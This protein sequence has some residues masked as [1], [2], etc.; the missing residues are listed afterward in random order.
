MG[1]IIEARGLV[2]TFE[3]GVTRIHALRG[4]DLDLEEG[5]YLAIVGPSGSGKSTL[6]NLL[7]CLDT[8][9][10]GTYRLAGEEVSQLNEL[11]LAAIRNR[12]IG[13]VF[14]TFNLLPATLRRPRSARRRARWG[15]GRTSP[16]NAQRAGVRRR[17]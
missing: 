14:Q 9:S 15:S 13:F 4:T 6:M 7:G 3:M 2:R 5:D 16:S 1:V 17:A 8:P 10:Q 11:E 12:R